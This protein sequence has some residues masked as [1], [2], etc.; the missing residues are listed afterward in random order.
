MKCAAQE[1][2]DRWSL[3]NADTVEVA[4]SL[5]DRSVDFAVYSP[6]FSSLYVYSAS[7]FDMGNVRDDAAFFEQ[8]DF[9]VREQARVMKPGRLIAIHCMTMPLSR[10]RDG[11]IGLKDFRGDLVRAHQRRGFIFH[12]EVCLWKDPV[13]QMQRTK[14]LGLLHKQ[15]RKDSAMSRQGLADYLVIMRTP[16]Q[17]PEP[18]AHTSEEFPVERWQRYA[19]PV[20]ATLGAPDDE[21]FAV[22]SAEETSDPSSGIN[23]SNTLQ[24]RSAR[25]HEDERHLAPLQLEV[26]RRAINLWTNKGDIVW[27]PFAGIG[28]EGVV[29][30]EMGRRFIGAELKSSYYRQAVANL[31]AA[32]EGGPQLS[33]FKEA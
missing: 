9:L 33:L 7:S 16:G 29:A 1:V 2:H 24:A 13:T 14:A 23:S 5:P 10:E 8:Y 22:C 32:R 27:S 21:G 19:S 20:W 25:E 26:I 12:S 15:I 31:K 17:N 3:F 28:S 18:I 11:V 30:L 6:P 4:R